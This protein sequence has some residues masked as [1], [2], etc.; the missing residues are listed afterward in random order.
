MTDR[1]QAILEALAEIERM[2]EEVDAPVMVPT[3]GRDL[4]MQPIVVAK[5][6]VVRFRRN[7]IVEYLLDRGPFDMN[8]LGRLDFPRE[9]RAQFAQ[10]IG[11]SVAGYGGLDYAV[12][13]E[14]ADAM[15]E[16]IGE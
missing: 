6:G 1:K 4:P 16:K 14:E 10:L 8:H 7:A 15:A 5:D 13:V 11:Y 2:V 12:G 9:D 3:P